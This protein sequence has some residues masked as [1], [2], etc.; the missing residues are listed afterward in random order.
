MRKKVVIG[1]CIV[2]LVVV[3]ILVAA[4]FFTPS[5]KKNTVS[6]S[7]G[8]AE[9]SSDGNSTSFEIELK[10][11]AYFAVGREQWEKGSAVTFQVSSD[12]EFKAE[13]GIIPAE[14][15]AEGYH[16]D[17]YGKIIGETVSLGSGMQTI[18]ITVPENGE[19]GIAVNYVIEDV[20]Q[21]KENQG[22]TV[23]IS[24]KVDKI[25][26]NPLVP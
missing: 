5:E 18:S 1:V 20:E 14:D 9:Y 16:Y 22:N 2:L 19:Y 7:G 15:M 24:L 21:T 8:T 11:G 3:C 26:Q 4:I 17:D 12:H 25:F 13:I 10:T 6:M 23:L